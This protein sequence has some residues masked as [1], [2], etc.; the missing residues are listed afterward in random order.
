MECPF[1]IK[2][3]GRHF[4]IE[5]IRPICTDDFAPIVS[6]KTLHYINEDSWEQ[7]RIPECTDTY[8]SFSKT[9]SL[10][11]IWLEKVKEQ[12]ESDKEI[13]E[14]V[15]ATGAGSHL[16][17][18]VERLTFSS[19]TSLSHRFNWTGCKDEKSKM[20]KISKNKKIFEKKLEEYRERHEARTYQDALLKLISSVEHVNGNVSYDLKGGI[21][22]N[23][24]H[25]TDED[26]ET[27]PDYLSREKEILEIEA[28]LNPLK[29]KLRNLRDE[30][31]SLRC[32]LLIEKVIKEDIPYDIKQPI[33]DELEKKKANGC[34][35]R[36]F[37]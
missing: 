32:N 3:Y 15:Y 27:I 2:K 24:N 31:H 16:K 25:Y 14:F 29:E 7:G 13:K 9:F 17:M 12:I 6:N 10:K 21:S 1:I 19:Q 28:T 4:Y 35:R 36:P 30:Q 26:V 5:Q 23:I 34:H 11:S 37:F 22:N 8:P 33:L 18:F 20:N